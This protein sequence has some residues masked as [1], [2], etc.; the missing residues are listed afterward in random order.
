ML[1][2]NSV[3][4]ISTRLLILIILALKLNQK[5]PLLVKEGGLFSNASSFELDQFIEQF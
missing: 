2:K 3:I 1:T 4:S 5:T